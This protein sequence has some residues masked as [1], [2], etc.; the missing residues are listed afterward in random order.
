MC[1]KWITKGNWPHLKKIELQDIHANSETTALEADQCIDI[2]LSE[3][4][5]S[6][7]LYINDIQGS[8]LD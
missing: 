6:K 3:F 8:K 7:C 2:I 4:Q 1:I 5:I